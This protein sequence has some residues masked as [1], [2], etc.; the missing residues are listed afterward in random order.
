V[1]QAWRNIIADL[2]L[3]GRAHTTIVLAKR[4]GCEVSLNAVPLALIYSVNNGEQRGYLPPNISPRASLMAHG[5]SLRSETIARR[6]GRP[7]ATV[8][9]A[10]KRL[11]SGHGRK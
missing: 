7:F 3:S 8:P 11:P 1:P 4:S 2:W 10:K 5:S 9:Y 6:F